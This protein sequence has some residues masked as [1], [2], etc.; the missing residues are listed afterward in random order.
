MPQSEEGAAR[1]VTG[2]LVRRARLSRH[3]GTR[4]Q[5]LP[6]GHGGGR[7]RRRSHRSGV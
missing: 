2:A 6:V 5:N 7:P 3:G 1:H 4:W